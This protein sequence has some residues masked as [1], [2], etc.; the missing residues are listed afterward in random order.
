MCHWPF[1]NFARLMMEVRRNSEEDP[2]EIVHLSHEKVPSDAIK[3]NSKKLHFCA[4]VAIL[5]IGALA[6]TAVTSLAFSLQQNRQSGSFVNI[7]ASKPAESPYPT[8]GKDVTQK[9]QVRRCFFSIYLLGEE[10]G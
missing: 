10:G 8:F 1:L 3:K 6:A 9:E 5:L 4:T 2:Y 7:T